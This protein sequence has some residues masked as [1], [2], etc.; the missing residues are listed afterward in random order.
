MKLPLALLVLFLV[1]SA[2][3]AA[4][5]KPAKP[6]PCPK[7]QVATTS[8]ITGEQACFAMQMMTTPGQAVPMDTTAK[9][10]PKPKPN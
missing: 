3:I 9:P 6:K 1:S 10:K 2:A 4:D 5:T 7:G 8:K